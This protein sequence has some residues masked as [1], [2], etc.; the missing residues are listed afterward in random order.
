MKGGCTYL[1]KQGC[2]DERNEEH[3]AG[4]E[5]GEQKGVRLE[6]RHLVEQL[7]PLPRR[8]G[9][10]APER[11][12]KHAPDTPHQ[13][14]QRECPGLQLLFRHQLRHDRS[15]D[16]DCEESLD[17]HLER[18][19]ADEPRKQK[20][21]GGGASCLPLPPAPPWMARMATAM[22]RL[23]ENPH[24]MKPISVVNRPSRMVGLRPILS[25]A[26]PQGTAVR[27]WTAEKVAPTSPA[28]RAMSFFLTPKLSIIS[29][30]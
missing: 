14:H 3:D 19:Y 22:G 25:D 18:G 1:E 28:H 29:G 26:Q 5:V 12:P 21:G 8:L 30:R 20:G 6:Q 17:Q 7:R 9:K 11:R 2:D 10:E 13:R 24:R 16:A 4:D 27:P 15:D 23:V